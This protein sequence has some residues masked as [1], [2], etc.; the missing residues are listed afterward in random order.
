MGRAHKH[1]VQHFKRIALNGKRHR[2]LIGQL[3]ERVYVSHQ[4]GQVDGL[5][6]GQALDQHAEQ[7]VQASKGGGEFFSVI[8]F[9]GFLP[10]A[11]YPLFI[12]SAANRFR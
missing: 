8:E 10:R 5:F 12:V 3:D 6:V 1:S 7:V 4:R 9:H 11:N 2:M